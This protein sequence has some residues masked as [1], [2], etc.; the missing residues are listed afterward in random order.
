MTP[1]R[2]S[3]LFNE[4]FQAASALLG[5]KGGEYAPGADRLANFKLA[6]LRLDLLP[7]QVLLV[8]LDKHLQAIQHWVADQ[9]AGTDRPRSEPITGRVLDAINYLILL[10]A[11]IEEREQRAP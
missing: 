8:Y 3:D 10:T 6:S 7:E 4:T 5:V 11:L 1:Q 9:V 2:L